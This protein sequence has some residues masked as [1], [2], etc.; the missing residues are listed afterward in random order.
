METVPT[1]IPVDTHTHSVYSFDAFDQVEL[2]CQKAIENGIRTLIITDHLD[3]RK[4]KYGY[5]FYFPTAQERFDIAA[6]MNEKYGS[7]LTLLTG[8]ELGDVSNYPEMAREHLEK[9]PYDFVLGS[10]HHAP[11]RMKVDVYDM[12]GREVL[13]IYFEEMER[14]LDFGN[15]DCLAHIDYPARL[16]SLVRR[17]IF[18][19]YEE[20]IRHILKRLAQMD[21]AL[22]I[23]SSGLFDDLGRLSPETWVLDIFKE[24]GGKYITLGSDCHHAAHIGRGLN[25]AREMALKAGFTEYTWYRDRQPITAPL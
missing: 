24:Y 23:N 8:V 17:N 20:Q 21:K 18:R 12:P 14:L 6:E 1:L 25:E 15:F 10:I 11:E 16:P 7:R 22:E 2:M 5:P 4:H 13:D 9:Y 3:M 19:E